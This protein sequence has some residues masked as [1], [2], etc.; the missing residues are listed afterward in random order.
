MC[1]DSAA[2]PEDMHN[3]IGLWP[4]HNQGGNQVLKLSRIT[5]KNTLT[6]IEYLDAIKARLHYSKFYVSIRYLQHI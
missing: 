3:P 6:R 4:C 2:K 1:I 5:E